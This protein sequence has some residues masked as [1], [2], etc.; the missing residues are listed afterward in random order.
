MQEIANRSGQKSWDSLR[1]E[2]EF[3]SHAISRV[4]K[5][6]Q[7]IFG[8]GDAQNLALSERFMVYRAPITSQFD[9]SVTTKRLKI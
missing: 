9:V 8:R 7:L 2:S 5:D 1:E 4:L 6:I 3:Q